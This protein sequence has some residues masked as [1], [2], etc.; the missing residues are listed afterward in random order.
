VVVVSLARGL[1]SCAG[2]GWAALE[3]VAKLMG[4]SNDGMNV[5]KHIHAL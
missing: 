3:R 2:L 5:M 4:W 1:E